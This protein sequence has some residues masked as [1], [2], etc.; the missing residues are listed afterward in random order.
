[1]SILDAV[2]RKGIRLISDPALTC[3][4]QPVS[5][6]SAVGAL[7]LFY[8]YSNGFCS[9][10]LTSM[11]PPLTKPAGCTRGTSSS[12]PFVYK[13]YRAWNGLPGDYLLDLDLLW[14]FALPY[15]KSEH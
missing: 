1:M 14:Y 8:Q 12:H 10:V 13:V 4:L 15:K 5:H 7:S 3:Y 11:I 9:S 6:R 2:Q